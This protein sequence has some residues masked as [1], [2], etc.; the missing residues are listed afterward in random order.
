MSTDL[1]TDF[2]TELQRLFGS[3]VSLEPLTTEERMGRRICGVDL[4][5]PLTSHQ[6]QLI[7]ALLDHYRLVSL[8]PKIRA[9][10]ACAT[11]NGWPITLARLFLTLKTT[12]II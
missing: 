4:T 7:V 10:F 2:E 8:Q 1:A 6:A 12:P 3:E 9:G 5:R 11:W